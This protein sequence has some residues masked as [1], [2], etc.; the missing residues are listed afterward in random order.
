MSGKSLWLF[1]SFLLSGQAWALG[2]EPLQR[3]KPWLWGAL[4]VVRGGG[5][6]LGLTPFPLLQNKGKALS[7]S[8]LRAQRDALRPGVTPSPPRWKPQPRPL[9]GNQ[10]ENDTR[11]ATRR[12]QEVVSF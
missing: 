7:S 6:V 8:E 5:L 1:L 12:D 2:A 4:L 3:A 10:P 11:P 9:G